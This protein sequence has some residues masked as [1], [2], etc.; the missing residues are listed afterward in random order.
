[1]TSIPVL[2]GADHPVGD[3]LDPLGRADRGSAVLLHDDG[4]AERASVRGPGQ[5]SS[6]LR[7]IGQVRIGKPERVAEEAHLEQQQV[8]GDL[9][10]ARRVR[11]AGERDH[12]VEPA[13]LHQR[14][15]QTQRVRDVDV[16]VGE[17]VDQ[18]ERP[19]QVRRVVE[20][21]VPR[22]RLDVGVGHPQV[23]LRVVRVVELAVRD[24]RAAHRRVE[25]VGPAQHR[26]RREEPAERPAADRDALEVEERDTAPPRRAGRRPDPR[27]RGPRGSG[28]PRGPSPDRGPASPARRSR[29]PRTPGPR[30]TATR[31]AA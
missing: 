15:R 5:R 27:A 13:R 7:R 24:G 31:A 25:H 12:R 3:G 29:A 18:Q 9:R 28:R 19:R 10:P 17:P 4:H 30:T 14:L 6:G 16:V 22:V 1:M 11:D 8:L 26:H 23:P 20:Q 21:P 2:L